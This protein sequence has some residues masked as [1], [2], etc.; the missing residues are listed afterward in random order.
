MFLLFCLL[1]ISCYPVQR[2]VNTSVV[3]YKQAD[4]NRDNF[5][6]KQIGILPISSYYKDDL[7]YFDYSLDGLLVS[8]YGKENVMTSNDLTEVLQKEKMYDDYY[9]A[10]RANPINEEI[11]RQ[12]ILNIGE[13]LGTDY[14]LY[15]RKLTFQEV[16]T[17]YGK[18]YPRYP[19]S[20]YHVQCQVWEASSGEIVWEGIGGAAKNNHPELVSDQA[21]QYVYQ[22]IGSDKNNKDREDIH[23]LE[24]DMREANNKT[25]LGALFGS[26]GGGILLGLLLVALI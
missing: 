12:V 6:S 13:V 21:A 9:L 10:V 25:M 18:N 23:V 24:E 17:M 14:I 15:N 8:D 22:M 26:I 11:L 5:L 7:I 16:E 20:E 3:Q 2:M 19:I 1:L 4:F